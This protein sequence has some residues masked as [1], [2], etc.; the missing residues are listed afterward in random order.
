MDM[1]DTVGLSGS[2][3]RA[4]TLDLGPPRLPVTI[5]VPES[6]A[7]AGR[8]QLYTVSFPATLSANI[9]RRFCLT[10]N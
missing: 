4:S 2:N 8:S 5:L 9:S 1:L 10:R 7:A 6:P 3:N